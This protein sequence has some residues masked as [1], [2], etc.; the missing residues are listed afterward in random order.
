MSTVDL[1]ILCI[2]GL[3]SGFLILFIPANYRRTLVSQAQLTMKLGRSI[4]TKT[5]G[6]VISIL[7]A[8]IL[9][10]VGIL[11][12]TQSVGWGWI[13]SFPPDPPSMPSIGAV[14][15]KYWLWF[16]ISFVILMTTVISLKSKVLKW[17][18]ILTGLFLLVCAETNREY[19]QSL[20]AP[21][22]P[23]T[24]QGSTGNVVT[25]ATFSKKKQWCTFTHT[26]RIAGTNEGGYLCTDRGPY[27]V[28]RSNGLRLTST[29]P[30]NEKQT[31]GYWIGDEAC[32]LLR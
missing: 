17:L 3:V 32:N 16:L 13:H 8:L 15:S 20:N 21:H 4:F 24:A 10:V 12:G 18:L 26:A 9:I 23:A 22:A 29:L 19:Q 31:V 11:V 25:C 6:I 14:V 5:G 7:I 2:A 1:A 27:N 30:G 28:E